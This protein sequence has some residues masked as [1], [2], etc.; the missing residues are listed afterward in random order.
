MSIHS[1]FCHCVLFSVE[2]FQNPVP[3]ISEIHFLIQCPVCRKYISY[4]KSLYRELYIENS[5]QSFSSA[6]SFC[7]IPWGAG[8]PDPILPSAERIRVP[9]VYMGIHR[10]MQ[11]T[12]NSAVG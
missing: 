10:Y 2:L 3:S 9:A 4:I 12:C 1:E 8:C 7:V 6:A 5:T 11:Y